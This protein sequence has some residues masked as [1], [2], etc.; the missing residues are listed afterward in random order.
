MKKSH[1]LALLILLALTA[2]SSR[3]T[4]FNYQYDFG[5]SLMI[6]GSLDGTQ[7][8]S[9]VEDISNVSLFYNGTQVTGTIFTARYNP[10]PS[11]WINGPIV[12]F[13]ALLN[14]FMFVNS[15]GAN[16]NWS[17]NSFF[18][19]VNSSVHSD[20]A[21]VYSSPQ[22]IS[23]GDVTHQGNWSLQAE[24]LASA[25]RVAAVVPVG[26][27]TFAMVGMGLLGLVALRRKF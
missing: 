15:D 23:Y 12:S 9:F 20:S 19:M 4:T 26:G 24:N 10:T 8:G 27:Q 2:R 22:G 16:G 14:N 13:N 3:A 17:F 6:S 18:Y 1:T 5:N 21:G 25:S 7:N 11:S